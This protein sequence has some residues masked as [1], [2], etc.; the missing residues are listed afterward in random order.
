[1]TGWG[2]ALTLAAFR[3]H[4][5]VVRLLL[6]HGAS[7]KLQ[8]SRGTAIHN[9]VHASRP[10]ILELLCSEPGPVAA[11]ACKN[12]QNQTPLAFA[13]ALG[14]AACEAALRAMGATA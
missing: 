13:R 5:S 6:E 9:A 14:R 7:V 8:D 12:H 4:I 11:M 2:T 10:D 1:M 3:G